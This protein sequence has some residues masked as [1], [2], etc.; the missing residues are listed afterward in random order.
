MAEERRSS[1]EGYEIRR[2]IGRGASAVVYLAHD[3]KHD[4]LV[5][6]KHLQSD[7]LLTPTRF[8]SEIHTLAVML[9]PHILPLHDSG[10][11]N[12]AP[13]YVMPYV[14]GM[15]LAERI[16]RDGALPVGEALR[17]TRDVAGALAHA[18]RHGVIH[19]DVKPANI[20]LADGHAYVADF[21]IA[22]VI[23]LASSMRVTGTGFAVG[24]P[25][26]MSPEQAS[27]E[28]DL[29]GRSDVYSLG[30]VLFEMLTGAPPFDGETPREMLAKRMAGPAPSA[31]TSER[32]VPELVDRII[33]RAM[34][35]NPGER[36]QSAE[37]LAAAIDDA[38]RSLDRRAPRVTS[39]RAAILAGLVVA[40]LTGATMVGRRMRTPEPAVDP[41]TYAVLPFRHGGNASNVWLDGDGCARLLHDAMARW[42]GVRIVDDMRVNDAWS[43]QRQRTVAA[44]F[45][46][47]RSLH[48]GQ[49]AWGEVLGVGDSLEI[50]AV[51]YD[52]M[53]GPDATRQ[54]VVRLARDAPQLERA[55]TALA[56][57][58]VIGGARGRDGAATGTRNLG[59][60]D[61]F[62]AGRAAMDSFDLPSA[63]RHFAAATAADESY[64][65]A[66]FWSARTAAWSGDVDPATWGIG[67]RRAL[68]LSASL[69]SREQ[70]HAAA[71]LDLAEGRMPDACRRF[72]RLIASDSLDFAAWFGLGDCNA[73]DPVV[74]R[75]AASPSGFAFRGSI[76]T[77]VLAYRRALA[78]AP[79][80]HRAERGVAFSRLS[81]RVLYT[82][83]A[84]LRRGVAPLPDG[85]QFAAFPSFAAETL[86][87][88]PAPYLT[89]TAV[90]ARPPTEHQAVA[91]G[92]E[93]YRQVMTEWVRAF[94]A[95]ADA[96]E[97][98]ALALESAVGLPGTVA[99]L[100]DA[101]GEV[102]VALSGTRATDD[103]VRRTSMRVRL[104]LKSDSV[105]AA[106]RLAD[107]AL[108]TWQ[109][110]SSIAA[111][112]LAGLAALT[113]RAALAA[114]LR[115]RAASDS[116][117]VPFHDRAGARASM[118][119]D[120][121][122]LA[123]QLETYAS[124]GGPRDSVRAV[125]ARASRLVDSRVP[126]PERPEARQ[127]LFRNAYGLAF[128]QLTPVVRFPL[129]PDRD[130]V[131]A[132]H[133]AI[134]SHDAKAIRDASSALA[135][136]T[137]GYAPGTVGLDRVH[138]YATMLL[139]LG[140]TAAATRELD[141]AL[142]GLPRAR[143]ILLRVMPQA[144]AV[145]P[146]MMLR[147]ELASRA[148]DTA[149]F[150]RW[151]R[152]A[153]TL[154]GGADASLRAPVES[155]SRRLAGP[156]RSRG[157][158]R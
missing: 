125:F 35:P 77:A 68:A 111:D 19:R 116:D 48:A 122:A 147:A 152:P 127:T 29:D 79:S 153:V 88:V 31:R 47:A 70:A 94:P 45:A 76:Y 14:D 20:L 112:Y 49:L 13:F 97:A 42:Q 2:E 24:T 63:S 33:G 36:Y 154:W 142:D 91:W 126:A 28:A 113:G 52:V 143:S 140:D 108:A 40:A 12:D 43:R 85:R 109:S 53:R 136:L 150:V 61:H 3:T 25:A 120:L 66:H 128:D 62:L 15:T 110:P 139:A 8:L 107:S 59:A 9:H 64:A 39:G 144:A 100:G 80:F 6:L 118:P 57:S 148:G 146:S 157:A 21:G 4:R 96:H 71:L 90:G 99:T 158:G 81:H 50:R 30:C 103:L 151:A 84:R 129:A 51:A 1:P 37:N 145:A 7:L 54:F 69:A 67:A 98:L 58:I 121:I 34:A 114:D 133:Q 102:G 38:T 138:R 132:M 11:W 124:L 135:R 26:Y 75:D 46:T 41:A 10:M 78:I 82:E 95:S 131:L 101:L 155:L 73:R 72:R 141:V 83:E 137:S 55:F 32:P 105:T 119:I 123:L 134:A 93:N 22:H 16:E 17:I 23:S 92:T 89:A 87:F 104:L 86:A 149:T 117:N 18:H 5:A 27:A 130:L 56:D 65:H 44:A 74:V 156:A 106:R 115:A 60:L